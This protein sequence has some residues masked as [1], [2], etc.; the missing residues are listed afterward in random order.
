MR[1]QRIGIF[2]LMASLLLALASYYLFSPFLREFTLFLILLSLGILFWAMYQN[3]QDELKKR[4]LSISLI[5]FLVLLYFS[6]R[7]IFHRFDFMVGDAS[8]Y[9][10][11]G[12]CAV[13]YS[14]DIGYIL[15]LSATFT[16]IG[17]DIFGIEYAL[18]VYVLF[19]ASTIPLFY[20]LFR[21]FKLSI[22]LSLGMSFFIIFIPLSIWYAKSSFSETLW[23]VL[24]FAF[25]LNSYFI[26]QKPKLALIDT[27]TLVIILAISPLLRVEGVFFFGLL[28][29]VLLY[30]FWKY[31][32]FFSM[33]FLSFGFFIIAISVHISLKLRPSYLLDRQYNRILP[34][35]TEE[36]VMILL[37][38]LSLGLF[39]L[40]FLLYI[41]RNFYA[42]IYFPLILVLLSLLS[43][44]AIAYF[45]AQKKSL[46]FIEVLFLNEYGFALG[47]FGLLM[48]ICIGIGL[49]L[50]Y[51]RAYKGELLAILFIVLYTV[52]MLPFTMQTVT[53]FDPHAFLFY[54]NRYYFSVF[55]I[56]HLFA[57]AL[58]LEWI[59]RFLAQKNIAY[60]KIIFICLTLVIFASSVNPK[61]QKI[62]VTEAHLKGSQKLYSWVQQY[63]GRQAISLVTQEGVIY[64]QNNRLDG[65]EK[66]EYLIGRTFS[67]Y[68]MPIKG[69]QYLH[70]Y[71]IK[72]L[73][74][75]Y[76]LCAS[77]KPCKLKGHR[78]KLID[79]LSLDLE[80]REHFGLDT[81][82]QE[83]H[84]NKIENSVIQKRRLEF[85]LYK[86]MKVYKVTQ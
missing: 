54:W 61:L 23:Q 60:F 76:V 75:R 39:L 26:L 65:Q 34:H 48:T 5:A 14:Q 3:L 63:V 44:V 20:L 22:L 12:F 66:I 53:F 56:I 72:K 77:E 36:S 59:Y 80:W 1:V 18:F 16:A 70:N 37:Y 82:A 30:H 32:H 57:F 78:L 31:R 10:A 17:Y 79:T 29:F 45:Y 68:K 19:Y 69:H 7:L 49:V 85:G 21:H 41:F 50:L 8:D 11:A 73:R 15:P 64:K 24:L 67:L 81:D 47:N 25:V 62:V 13:T 84:Q 27:V 2:L 58:V 83:I 51:I 38:G 9:F 28:L 74:A 86:K 46:E 42:K 4:W 33:L 6:Q 35:A 43:K 71:E 40:I 52:F 55:M